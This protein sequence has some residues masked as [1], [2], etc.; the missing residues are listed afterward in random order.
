MEYRIDT[1]NVIFLVAITTL[2]T[3]VQVLTHGEVLAQGLLLRRFF[4]FLCWCGGF[5]LC[6]LGSDALHA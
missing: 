1:D 5:F 6:V 4:P 3:Q 2:L